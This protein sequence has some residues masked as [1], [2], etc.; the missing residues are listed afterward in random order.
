MSNN[1]PSGLKRNVQSFGNPLHRRSVLGMRKTRSIQVSGHD[2]SRQS[3]QFI[4]EE[5][6]AQ[7]KSAW[8][9]SSSADEKN[10]PRPKVASP[11]PIRPLPNSVTWENFEEKAEEHRYEMSTWKMYNRITTSRMRQVQSEGGIPRKHPSLFEH[12]KRRRK[13]DHDLKQSNTVSSPLDTLAEE[14][15]EL[16]LL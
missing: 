4:V 2:S 7:Q 16:D 11:M 9:A 13:T 6:G 8:S 14:P 10:A 1:N 15:F 3:A 5:T 12:G